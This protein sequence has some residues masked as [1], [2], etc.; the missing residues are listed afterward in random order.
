MLMNLR[1]MICLVPRRNLL[2][3]KRLVM[4]LRMVMFFLAH[5]KPNMC[6]QVREHAAKNLMDENNL[7][8]IFGPNLLRAPAGIKS[9][10]YPYTNLNSPE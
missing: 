9:I 1:D 8:V 7:G 10:S 5:K 4:T 3:L 2:L 6:C